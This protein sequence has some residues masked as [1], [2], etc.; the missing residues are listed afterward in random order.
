MRTVLCF[1]DS[2]TW[3]YDPETDG[4]RPWD[5]RW[6]GRLQHLLGPA[7]R[8]VEEGLNGRT[9]CWEDPL[10]R[11]RNGRVMLGPLL[12]SHAPVDMLVL[13]LGTNDMKHRFGLSAYDIAK[14]VQTLV[15]DAFNNEYPPRRILWVSPPRLVVV[16]AAWAAEYQHAGEKS[17]R[18]GQ[19]SE[20]LAR[21][22]GALFLNAAGVVSGAHLDGVH[23][24][25]EEHEALAG[26]VAA[27]VLDEP[28]PGEE[29]PPTEEPP[30]DV[31]PASA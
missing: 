23:L 19:C 16:R 12:E 1:G 7:Y 30:V 13:M 29:S 6:P 5:R 28:A 17:A 25:E 22:S 9:A 11:D 20:P 18:L 26:A 4:R 27:M 24:T 31:P 8:V 2:N 14:G 15:Q 10:W 21:E 3:G